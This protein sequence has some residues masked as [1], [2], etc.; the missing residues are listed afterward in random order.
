M[1][2]MKE[3]HVRIKRN[4]NPTNLSRKVS[5]SIRNFFLR[6]VI[7]RITIGLKN[8]ITRNKVKCQK[9]L[10]NDSLINLYRK[11]I[12]EGNEKLS[13]TF[14]RLRPFW[15]TVPTE[16]YRKTYLCKHCENCPYVILKLQDL[17]LLPKCGLLEIVKTITCDTTS[18]HSMYRDCAACHDTKVINSVDHVNDMVSWVQ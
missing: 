14:T 1:L 8:T 17:G 10:L 9:R 6:Y 7:S 3:C 16:M 5:R 4:T 11:Y 12:S 13:Y 2:K 15:V 18:K